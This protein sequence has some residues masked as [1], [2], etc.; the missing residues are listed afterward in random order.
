[1]SFNDEYYFISLPRRYEAQ[2]MGSPPL[3]FHNDLDESEVL[4]GAYTVAGPVLFAG[5]DLVVNDV[6]REK[7]IDLNIPGM[8]MHSTIYI[9]ERNRWHENYWYL[10]FSTPLD[11]WDRMTSTVA[12]TGPITL[13]GFEL[14]EVNKFN[15]DDKV[16]NALPLRE[17]RLFK[18]AG[19]LGAKVTAH[20]SVA[21][22]FKGIAG[23]SV[24][25]IPISAYGS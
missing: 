2:P 10:T 20:Q 21:A 4:D 7:L 16:L 9:D 24:D 13:G 5:T 8:H 6:I 17:R 1:M 3:V 15:L 23:D 11:C 12:K 18:M 19:V 22:L 25:L 14:F